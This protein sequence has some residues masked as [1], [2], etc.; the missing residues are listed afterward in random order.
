MLLTGEFAGLV[1][2]NF[3][4]YAYIPGG[5]LTRALPYLLLGMF[6]REKKDKLKNLPAW[7]YVVLFFIGG[8]LTVLEMYLLVRTGK[9]VYQAHYIGYGIMAVAVCGFAA[10]K[11]NM[12][13]NQLSMHGESFA[14]RVYAF[15]NPVYYALFLFVMD[16]VPQ[17]AG[18]FKFFGGLIV[19]L[20]CLLI[21]VAISLVKMMI[22][23]KF[24]EEDDDV[25]L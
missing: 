16:R 7:E 15:H 5:W 9:L 10:V 3:L 23:Q 12:Q 6:L 24:D 14:K 25:F 20:V 11:E 4:G 22:P 19:Y 17:N 2:F 13:K 18:A 21:C 8:G 1:G